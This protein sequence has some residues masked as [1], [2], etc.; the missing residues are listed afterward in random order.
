MHSSSDREQCSPV[1]LPLVLRQ[2]SAA[3]VP[4]NPLALSALPKRY[5]QTSSAHPFCV[6]LRSI[7]APAL[8]MLSPRMLQCSWAGDHSADRLVSSGETPRTPQL[9]FSCFAASSQLAL[10]QHFKQLPP[11]SCAWPHLACHF[12]AKVPCDSSVSALAFALA[13]AFAAVPALVLALALVLFTPF[14]RLGAVLR[15]A[16]VGNQQP[17]AVV[18][19]RH[20]PA[21]RLV[22]GRKAKRLLVCLIL[23]SC[24]HFSVSMFQPQPAAGASFHPALEWTATVNAL[25]EQPQQPALVANLARL[26]RQAQR[27]QRLLRQGAISAPADSERQIAQV[28]GHAPPE[29]RTP[30][31]FPCNEPG[32]RN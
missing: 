15:A 3:L 13:L 10:I 18:C 12:S 16:S 23:S 29:D 25:Q 5:I 17:T 8:N 14:C 21:I 30:P 27:T 7:C 9:P 1:L 24:V 11:S 2:C 4:M 32:H 31:V 19:Q 22:Q 26:R 28:L 20:I 6:S